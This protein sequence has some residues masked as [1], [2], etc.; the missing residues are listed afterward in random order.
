VL[1]DACVR[2]MVLEAFAVSQPAWESKSNK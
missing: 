2:E 1:C